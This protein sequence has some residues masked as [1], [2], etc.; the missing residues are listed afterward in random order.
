MIELLT[1]GGILTGLAIW[2]FWTITVIL[3]G[4]FIALTEHEHWAWATTLFAGTLVTLGLL[5]IFNLYKFA[6]AHPT[7]LLIYIGSYIG[8]G[9]VYGVIK[10]Y[11]FCRKQLKHYQEAKADFLKANH[12]TEMTPELRV[13]WTEKLK[14]QNKFDRHYDVALQAPVWKEHTETI[15]NWM[16]L[17]P[18]SICGMVLTDFMRELWEYLCKWM[19]GIYDSIAKAVWRGIEKDL[20]SKEDIQLAREAVAYANEVENLK[21]NSRTPIGRAQ[22]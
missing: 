15:I 2:G 8:I 20:A 6:W 7:T 12:K 18:F 10:W 13:E 17:W 19:G 1:L 14:H 16:Y 21:S 3:F 4:V 5:G 22:R 9:L 11:F